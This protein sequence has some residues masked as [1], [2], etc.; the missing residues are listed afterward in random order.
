MRAAKLAVLAYLVSVPAVDAFVVPTTGLAARSTSPHVVDRTIR[1]SSIADSSALSALPD[2]SL[3]LAASEVDTGSLTTYFIEQL[4]AAGVPAMF[5]IVV[6][7]FAGKTIA[8]AAK[9]DREERLGGGAVQELYDDLYTDGDAN[10]KSPF[11]GG[12]GPPGAASRRTSKKNLGIPSKEYIKVT[13]LNDKF[14]SYGYSLTAATESKALAAAQLRSSNFDRALSR[15]IA[16]GLTP[17]TPGEKADLIRV[18]KELLTVGGK[19]V[20]EMAALQRKMTDVVIKNEMTAMNV[21]IG[22]VDAE[23]DGG[24]YVQAKENEGIIVD[25][26]IEEKN[27]V[28][29]PFDDDDKSDV[30][31]D[32]ANSVASSGKAKVK[33]SGL[34]S[35][36]KSR[37]LNADLKEL[38]ELNTEVTKLELAFVKCVIEILGPERA[39]GVRAAILGNEAGGTAA[40]GTLLKS[41]QERPLKSVLQSLG[42]GDEVNGDADGRKKK[43]FVADFPGDVSASQVE[44]L[45]EEVTA[46]IRT[47][48]PGD[49]ALVVLQS[50]GGTV[51]GYGLAA[52]QLSRFKQA[53]MKLTIC[54]EQVAASGGYMMACV[55]D[56]IV[57]SPFA[58]LGSIGV[59]SDVPNFY[60]RLKDEGIEFQTI[61]AG[62]YKRT[63]TPTKKVTNEDIKKSKEDVEDIL[64]LFKA[65]VH[66]NRPQL[67]IDTVATGE[68]WFGTDALDKGLCDDIATADD[69]LVQFVDQG[70]DVFEVKYDPQ[71][72]RAAG[73]LAALPAG[74]VDGS[75]LVKGL[76]GWAVRSI[77]PVAKEAL[78]EEVRKITM[79]QGSSAS[80]R[81]MVKDPSNTVDRIR[82]QD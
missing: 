72:D 25:A 24:E 60:Q 61:T 17:L 8:S 4:I 34:K 62:K 13:R 53:G 52:A 33:K 42:Y 27:G 7:A 70:Y 77:A 40:A 20:S 69:V 19:I 56:R 39:N 35:M 23:G 55:A 79:E 58:V 54:V 71:S 76:V 1:P 48:K 6:I 43:L 32:A 45:R 64:K 50:G 41:L 82:A 74:Q 81:Y 21:Q 3:L 63:V 31:S 51:T 75:G 5:W 59:I 78:E 12:F 57:A 11:G 37:T 29:E 10:S 28:V 44:N 26:V 36:L 47:A 67:D 65:F 18:E 66:G 68:T 15:S 16:S 2:P 49:E 46:I 9:E 22:E 14:D 80:K 38:S 30:K 73:L